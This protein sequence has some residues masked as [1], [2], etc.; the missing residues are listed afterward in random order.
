MPLPT[1]TD[2]FRVAINYANV[3]NSMTAT[4][5]IHVLAPTFD[6]Q[7]VFDALNANVSS[8]MWDPCTNALTTEEVVITKLDGT[9]DGRAFGIADLTG[10]WRQGAGGTQQFIPQMAAI[11][12]LA[13]GASGRSGRGR[14]FLPFVSEGQQV[15]GLIDATSQGNCTAAWVAFANDLVTASMALAVASYV[16]STA[17]QVLNLACESHSGTIRK[18]NKR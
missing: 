18:R 1:I 14:I 8:A 7:D 3:L 10:D 15:N 9:P 5:V 17:S 11:V 6:E 16:H 4:N 12:K 13:T 2:C